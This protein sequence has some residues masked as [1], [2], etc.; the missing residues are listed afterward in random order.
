M[1]TQQLRERLQKLSAA[2]G[3]ELLAT[4][5][6]RKLAE[7]KFH[8][9]CRNASQIASL[10]KDTYEQLHGNKKFYRTVAVSTQF[11]D[12]WM[13]D[14]VKGKVFLDYACGNGTNAIRAAKVGANLAI[15]MDISNVSVENCKKEAAN[16]GVGDKTFFFQGDCER[17]GLPDGCIDVIICSGMLHHLDLSY[18][19]YELRRI[20]R[21][22]GVVLA[23][24]ALDYNPVIKLYRNMTP[25]MRTEWEKKHILSLKDLAFA[26]RFFEVGNVRYWH[27]F[28]IAGAYFPGLLPALNVIDN[29]VLQ[30]PGVRLLS[31]MWTFELHKRSE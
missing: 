7:L 16:E 27:L 21:P 15:G 22:G 6:H 2:N 29:L 20:L 3:D 17:T 28:S 11:V 14:H 1:E 18:A 25:R 19:F 10:P 8:N 23:I 24:E 4:L 12:G 5:N 31:W 9:D 26:E 30:I 13:A